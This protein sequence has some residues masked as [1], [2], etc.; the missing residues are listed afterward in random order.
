MLFFIV[1]IVNSVVSFKVLIL[2]K[3]KMGRLLELLIELL[4]G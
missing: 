2:W 4:Y 1:A 3:L